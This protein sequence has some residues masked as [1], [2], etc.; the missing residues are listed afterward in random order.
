MGFWLIVLLLAILMSGIIFRRHRRLMRDKNNHYTRRRSSQRNIQREP[1]LGHNPLAEQAPVKTPPAVLDEKTV[2]SKMEDP[3]EVLGLKPVQSKKNTPS[4]EPIIK[5]IV[6]RIEAL[7]E[8]PFSGYEL[9]QALL[10]TGLRY[11][12]MNIFHRHE[13]KTG[14]G[15]LLFSVA[16]SIQPGTF[17]LQKMGGFS[18]KGL[19]L[20]FSTNKVK[21]P[22]KVFELMLNT[23]AQLAED[24]G[25]RVLDEERQLL[26]KA[27]IVEISKWIRQFEESHYTADLF[28]EYV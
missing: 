4:P 14:R 8:R 15:D 25:G 24:L 12:K 21:E 13:Q 11:G 20:F 22:L 5:H 16:S 7:V 19:T 2:V 28:S 9:L 26:S 6:L 23:A 27:K 17:D 18:T 10:A 3:D 1:I